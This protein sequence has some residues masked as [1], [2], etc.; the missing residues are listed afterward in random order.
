[1]GIVVWLH[2]QTDDTLS[3]VAQLV[4]PERVEPRPMRPHRWATHIHC[5]MVD[6][7][8]ESPGLGMTSASFLVEMYPEASER[9]YPEFEI[10]VF[11]HDG[12]VPVTTFQAFGPPRDGEERIG[13]VYMFRALHQLL[14][15]AFQVPA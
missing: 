9:T 13:R 2:E 11:H 4:A 8:R 10:S 6:T 14:S 5:S 12:F 3:S 1:M 7:A 15:A